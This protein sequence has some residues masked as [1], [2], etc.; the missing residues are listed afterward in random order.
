MLVPI[1]TRTQFL[2]FVSIFTAMATVLDILPIIPG[3]Y[4]GI[5]DSWLFIL[6]PIIGIILGPFAGAISVGLGTTIGHLIY[7]R[8]PF[9]FVF[10]LGA[11]LGAAMTGFIHRARWP[12]VLGVYSILLLSYFI[13]PVAWSLT[14]WGIWDVLLG[15]GLLVITSILLNSN[16]IKQKIQENEK[17]LS[18]LAIII[19]LETDILFRVFVFVPCQTYWFFYGLTGEQL[20]LIW[21]GAGFITPIKVLLA[22]IIGLSIIMSL[23]RAFPKSTINEKENPSNP[24]LE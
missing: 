5:W 17:V 7:F 23:F 6:S 15:F 20:Q 1:H 3:F 16:T 24:L 11:P 14:F 13:T 8:D 9:E 18:T 10:M 2:A 19:G 22:T 12:P 21:I 4:S